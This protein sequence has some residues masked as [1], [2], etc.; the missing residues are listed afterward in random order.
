MTE[1]KVKKKWYL[2]WWAIALWIFLGLSFLGT[3][4]GEESIP[5]QKLSKPEF[6][7]E[8]EIDELYA[9]FSDLSPYS[10]IQKEELYNREYKGKLIRTSIRADRI[11]KASLGSQYVV[12]EMRDR[13]SCI[14]KAFFSSSEKDKLLKANVGSTI[15]FAGKLEA[16]KYGFASCVE[17]SNSKVL[18]IK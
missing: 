17:F 6:D 15:I 3:L 8:I 16:Y 2:R 10:E 5:T 11:N 13:F 4:F 12:L 1:P 14:A 18:E 7:L 9:A